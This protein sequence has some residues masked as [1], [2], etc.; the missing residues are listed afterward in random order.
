MD[1]T[2]ENKTAELKRRKYADTGLFHYSRRADM[3]MEFTRSP[4]DVYAP[5]SLSTPFT[6]SG[7]YN[8]RKYFPRNDYIIQNPINGA[9]QIRGIVPRI[10]TAVPLHQ[11]SS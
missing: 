2:V 5:Y 10:R 7:S 1:V 8:S 11:N 9:T 3:S 4:K 6:D